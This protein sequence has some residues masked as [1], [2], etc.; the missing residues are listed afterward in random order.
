MGK[1]MNNPIVRLIQDFSVAELVR[2]E[3][4]AAG[5]LQDQVILS[6]VGDEAGPGQSNFTVG[7]APQVKGGTDYNDIYRPQGDVHGACILK[8]LARDPDQE[9]LVLAVLERHRAAAPHAMSEQ[10]VP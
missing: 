10:G 8:V 7:D 3:L 2:V 9:Q 5:L 4:L 1:S 6:P